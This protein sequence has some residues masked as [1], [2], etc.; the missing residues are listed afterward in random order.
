MIE[1]TFGYWWQVHGSREACESAWD[2]GVRA[3]ENETARRLKSVLGSIGKV[4][5]IATEIDG[6]EKILS[7]DEIEAYRAAWEARF[8]GPGRTMSIDEVALGRFVARSNVED[9]RPDTP[10][11]RLEVIVGAVQALIQAEFRDLR[12]DVGEAKP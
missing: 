5:R 12:F 4:C 9:D 1:K 2:A 11:R 3:S 10:E 8:S 7:P 6:S